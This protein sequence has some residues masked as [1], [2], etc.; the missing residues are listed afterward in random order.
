MPQWRK[1][2]RLFGPSKA[3]L[4][5]QAQWLCS[6]QQGSGW[7][8]A[9]MRSWQVPQWDCCCWRPQLCALFR[10]PQ[11]L[12]RATCLAHTSLMALPAAKI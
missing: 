6:R 11:R 9:V 10:L 8:W 5:A 2:N 4:H 12:C 3:A 7:C 1:P